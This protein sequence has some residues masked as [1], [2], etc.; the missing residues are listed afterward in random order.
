MSNDNEI[1][2]IARAFA[3][4]TLSNS[5]AFRDLDRGTQFKMYNDLVQ[6]KMGELQAGQGLANGMSNGISQ[7]M[8]R[9]RPRARQQNAPQD[10]GEMLNPSL[11]ENE[12]LDRAGQRMGDFVD[13][14]DFPAFVS[15]LLKGVFDANL[16]VTQKQM[17]TY[18]VLLKEASKDLSQFINQIDNT[19]AFGYLVENKS[20]EFGM[21]FGALDDEGKETV[22]LTN[23]EGDA[24]DTEDTK[25]KGMIMNAKIQMAKE[26]RA[27]L[28]E[29]LLMGVTRLVVEKGEVEASV[30]FQINSRSQKTTAEQAR[31]NKQKSG[32]NFK[33]G[34]LPFMPS[35]GRGVTQTQE[36]QISIASMNSTQQDE[37][38]AK[39][40]GKVRIE[41]KSD[42]FKLDNFAK[43]YGG[44]SDDDIAEAKTSTTPAK[45]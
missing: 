17:Q 40:A 22:I 32:K 21:D 35:F 7:G 10:A 45:S 33:M 23:K 25:I 26:Q 28:R 2:H 19:A 3:R 12:N 9:Q 43:M 27:L 42:Y 41:F 39:L 38:S 30:Q 4:E 24:V 44:L 37:M 11:H 29:V 14:V 36:T 34:M 31:M 5:A 13:K 20:D 1:K 16:D 8:A 6:Q 15:D 18:Q